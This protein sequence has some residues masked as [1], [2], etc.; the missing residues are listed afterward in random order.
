MQIDYAGNTLDTALGLNITGNSQ[1]F[2]DSV[3]SFNTNDYY[4]FTLSS[5]S[6]LNLS[7][8]GLSANADLEL[9]NSI[10]QILQ[11]SA[12]PDTN[13][14][15]ICTTLE[16][17]TYY[18]HAY[19]GADV[20]ANYNLNFSATPVQKDTQLQNGDALTAFGNST[21]ETGVFTVGQTGEVTIDFLFDGG[22]YQGELAIFSLDGM[23]E[24]E[25]S[26]EAFIQE[27][28]S[29]AVSN[30]ELGHVVISDPTEGARF[31][32]LLPYES[33]FNGGEYPGV[34]SVSMRPSDTFG[35][36]LVPNGT[37]QQV[38]DNPSV[39][40]AVRPLFSMAMA[41]PEDAFHVGQIADVMGDGSTFVMEDLRVDTGTDRDYNDLI[42]QV[43]GATGEAAQLDNLIDPSKD[44]RG[45]ELG[46][47]LIAYA[48]TEDAGNTLTEAHDFGLLSGTQTSLGFVGNLDTDDY[49]RFH[50]DANSNF[51]L[52]LNGLNADA[53]VRLIQDING[54]GLV[55][56]EEV[57]DF[58]I[59]SGNTPETIEKSLAAGDYYLWVYQYSGNTNYNLSL[60]ATPLPPDS[61]GNTLTAAL[62]LGLL[63][64]T[65]TSTDLLGNLDTDD[66]YRFQVD[67][68]SDFR[69]DLDGLSADADVQL[70]QDINGNGVVDEGEVLNSST[71]SSNTPETI[72]INALTAGEYFVR[73]YQYSGNTNYELSLS[74]TP[75]PIP[76]DSAGNTLTEAQVLGSLSGSQTFGDFIG[77]PDPNDYYRFHLDTNSN[78]RL[79]LNGLNADADVQL[80]RDINGNGMVDEGEVIDFST[81]SGNTPE[82]IEKSLAAGDYYIRVYQYSGDTNYNLNLS[83]TTI[84]DNAGNALAEARDFDLLS[85]T[86][87]ANDFV[88]DGDANDYYSFSLGTASNFDLSLTGLSADANVQ[89]LNSSGVVI[90]GSANSG[91]TSELISRS[92]A[93][94]TY[95]VQVSP[96]GTGANTFYDLNLSATPILEMPVDHVTYERLWPEI[97]DRQPGDLLLNGLY[98]VD[99]VFNDPTTG[100]YAVGLVSTNGRPPVLVPG[101][102]DFEVADIFDDTNPNGVGFNQFINNREEVETWLDEVSNDPLKNPS[103]APPDVIGHSLGG[104]LAQHIAVDYTSQGK[105]LGQIVTFN[106]PG[107]DDTVVNLFQEENVEE[108]THYIATGDIVSLAGEE[109]LPGNF[110]RLSWSA[111]GDSLLILPHINN[112]HN[113]EDRLTSGD[114]SQAPPRSVE[115]FSLNPFD[116]NSPA[117]NYFQYRDLDWFLFESAVA[118]I[119]PVG[120][121]LATALSTRATAEAS[122]ASIGFALRFIIANYDWILL[123]LQ[124]ARVILIAKAI[125]EGLISAAEAIVEGLISAAEAI[126]E[127]LISVAE[128]I[129]RGFI[130]AGEAI[131]QGFISA[132]EA[133]AQG[134][135][136]AGEAIA[137]GFI[138]AGE[139]IAQGFISA[140]E[141]IKNSFISVEEALSRGFIP[142]G[143]AIALGF[144]SV[145]VAIVQGFISAADAIAQGFISVEVAIAR[146]L[147]SAGDAIIRGFISAE[148]AI[149]RGFISAA[150]AIAGGFIS[151]TDAIARGLISAG[152]AIARGFISAGDAIARGFISAGDAIARG[153][154]SRSEAI[155]RGFISVGGAI[156]R[157][158]GF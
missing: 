156:K 122:R 107:I 80:I 59:A 100:F 13:A 148:V 60:S 95:Y 121:G 23:D 1:T 71:A 44:W 158:F 112:K 113:A 72:T 43:R 140:G 97:D 35:V 141:A 149:R 74:A 109:F 75:P 18:I 123:L 39:G 20:T 152:D 127:G 76:P 5:R 73:V 54:N 41:N 7:L 89:I 99:Q 84:P 27:A 105:E 154:I 9:L 155:A 47:A 93:A 117:F 86:Q 124:A 108:V 136:S 16:A 38:L 150:D 116:L 68:N 36:M 153:F 115:G 157:F 110:V 26:S 118:L 88:G 19:P 78:F 65:Q 42:F 132:G 57:L 62:D 106:S 63:S 146:G 22:L 129:A 6:N 12:Q 139:A 24:F 151:A 49:Y 143:E 79:D 53:D 130:S 64:G 10:G 51:R 138:S 81:A 50:L 28:A 56:E 11:T 37:V 17:G 77:N 33:D 29:R 103:L 144:I 2:R 3:D 85:G 14:E 147:I 94:G 133:I 98:K 142:A 145:E 126:V 70:I 134:F 34:K 48:Q 55:D 52:D 135:I 31:S 114:V 128:A 82:A 104:A 30:S 131:A 92:L 90:E 32:G 87:T 61:A 46:K 66:Y 119:L 102:T 96:N 40:D 58:S 45:S 21:F 83:A 125:A 120:P 69:L 15:S 137:Q 91:T 25:P 4:S 8:S 111:P 101:G 67:T